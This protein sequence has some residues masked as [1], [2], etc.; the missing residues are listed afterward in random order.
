MKG[1]V[2]AVLMMCLA[3]ASLGAQDA[4]RGKKLYDDKDCQK[5]HQIAGKGNKIGKLDGIASKMSADEMR[6]WL[7]ETVEM[8]KSLAKKP[9][10]KMSS[11]IKLMNL[12]A[13]DI[14]ALVAY[15]QTLK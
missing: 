4:S 7:T 11:K 2:V 12:G 14:D 8:E 13:A 6:R 10:V 1:A 9:K 3:G 5:C 15:M